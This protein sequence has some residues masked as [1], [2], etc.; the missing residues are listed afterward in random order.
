MAKKQK[1]TKDELVSAGIKFFNN[2]HPDR[3]V[4]DEHKN[5]P[6]AVA[7]RELRSLFSRYKRQQKELSK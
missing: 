1:I 5:A 6:G 4:G 2:W 7:A 3:W